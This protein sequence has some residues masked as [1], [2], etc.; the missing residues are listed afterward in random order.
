MPTKVRLYTPDVSSECPLPY[1]EE[2]V[3]A[4]FPSPADNY[5]TDSI[6]LNRALIKSPETTFFARAYGDSMEEAN[7]HE[8]D[9]LIVDRSIPPTNGFIVVAYISGE[10]VLKRVFVP[11]SKNCLFLM[12]EN[13]KYQPIKVTE[14]TSLTIWGVVTY[15]IKKQIPG[16]TGNDWNS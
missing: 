14:E 7:I 2:G 16:R 12:P 5:M 1:S 15:N 11:D 9:L 13:P 8:G 6:D 3:C 10:F 4:G